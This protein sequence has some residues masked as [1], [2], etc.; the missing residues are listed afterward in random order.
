[1][2]Q[3]AKASRLTSGWGETN[4]SADDE[5][6][7]SLS[8]LRSRSRALIRDAAYAKR[9]KRI[10]VDNV[11]GS[12]I[13]IQAQVKSTRGRLQKR[14]NDDIEAAWRQWSRPENCTVGGS[15]HFADLERMVLG[16]V[17]EAGEVF[18][19]KHRRP[20][21][22]SDIAYTL[23]V[24][25]AER[26]AEQY[27]P[28]TAAP[29]GLRMGVE[30][31]AF[32]RPE[33]YWVYELHPS[34]TR[35]RPEQ[36]NQVERVPARDILHLRIIDRWPQTR[37]EPWLHTAIRK[38]EDLD[39]YSEAEIIA[40]RGAASYLAAIET[41][42][43]FAG[44]DATLGE[45]T[46]TGGR[47]F[48]LEPGI[49]EEL[50]AGKRLNFINPSRPNSGVDPFLRYM[51]REI[52]AGTGVSYESLSKDYSQSNY[53]SSRL[54]LLEDRDTWRALQL[55]FIRH[56][57]DVVHREWL[58][59]AVMANAVASVGPQQF[60]VDMPRYQAVRFKPRG[61][62]WVDP[63]K[64]VGAYKE[65][66]RAGFTT[67]SQV[68]AE[69]SGGRDGEDVWSERADELDKMKQLGLTFDTD[70]TTGDADT[71]DT[72]ADETTPR[73]APA[74]KIAR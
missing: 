53:S 1:M 59:A 43:E 47:E 34:E 72:P 32:Y 18:I 60:F 66:V 22:D 69:T 67:T 29:A 7:T 20:F 31:G 15:L 4:A 13:G 70:T 12:G 62:N 48:T 36:T 46:E 54:S 68:I 37:G 57:R 8:R 52:A 24:I 30:L 61:W 58:T 38:L 49:V 42:P 73:T 17:F 6:I 28:S 63:P 40:A 11:V 2:Y 71:D 25:E 5:L 9:A 50:P 19:R 51:L 14:I 44:T 21:G 23:E 65:A 56:F 41:D 64:E 45:A 74:L 10:V 55:W 33:A 35:L 27:T 26:I 16:Q 39:G 3:G